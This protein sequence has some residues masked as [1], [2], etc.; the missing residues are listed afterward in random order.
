[1]SFTHLNLTIEKSKI[2]TFYLPISSNN[3][4]HFAMHMVFYKKKCNNYTIHNFTGR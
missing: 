2:D 3:M 1:M 4:G